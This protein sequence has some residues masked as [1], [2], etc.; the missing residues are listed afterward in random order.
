MRGAEGTRYQGLD[1]DFI[2]LLIM[3]QLIFLHSQ[4]INPY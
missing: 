2:A 1:L 3:I 4:P